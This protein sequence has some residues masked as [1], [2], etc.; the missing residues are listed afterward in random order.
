MNSRS[1]SDHRKIII[2]YHH[3]ISFSYMQW[4]SSVAYHCDK[5][6]KKGRKKKD[7]LQST[8][9]PRVLGVRRRKK[10]E[11]EAREPKF[12]MVTVTAPT[13]YEEWVQ[14]K[15][16]QYDTYLHFQKPTRWKKKWRKKKD[17]LQSAT[18]PRV[19]GVRRR[20]KDQNEERERKFTMVTITVLRNEWSN[21]VLRR[22]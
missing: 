8:I 12:T 10:D 11:N 21:R 14:I 5:R 13:L 1:Q 2:K 3:A 7:D 16:N 19:L 15:P 4:W 17:D 20:K 6:K 18:T 22:S 9:T